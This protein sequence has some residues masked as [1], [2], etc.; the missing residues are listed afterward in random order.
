MTTPGWG[1]ETFHWQD[2][3]PTGSTAM[4]ADATTAQAQQD[5]GATPGGAPLAPAVVPVAAAGSSWTY[6]LIAALAIGGYL[7][8][9]W[10]QQHRKD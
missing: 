4:L 8:W 9:R 2:L 7:A 1:L 10:W 6:I 5:G 3:L